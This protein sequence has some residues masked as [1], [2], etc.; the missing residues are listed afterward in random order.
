MDQTERH[1]T[2]VPVGP[3]LTDRSNSQHDTEGD[4]DVILFD[5]IKNQDGDY[6]LRTTSYKSSSDWIQDLRISRVQKTSS[7][8]LQVVFLSGKQVAHH[9]EEYLQYCNLPEHSVN[10]FCR[11]IE[12]PPMPM[13]NQTRSDHYYISWMKVYPFLAK[14]KVTYIDAP[15]AGLPFGDPSSRHERTPLV[16]SDASNRSDH[17]SK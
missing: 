9:L 3:A 14:K 11:L 6:E 5:Y 7:E 12:S 10:R 16:F 2:A 17:F 1:P 8:D 4:P 15:D 13:A